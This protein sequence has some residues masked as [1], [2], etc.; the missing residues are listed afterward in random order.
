MTDRLTPLDATFL[1]L[2]QEDDCAHMHI[3]GALVFDPRADGSI[4][5]VEEL[6]AHLDARLGHLPRY[7][8]RLSA[9]RT[10]GLSWPVWEDD[11]HFDMAA[12]VRHA[13]LPAPG[14]E[15]ELCEWLGDYWSHRL[16]RTRPL[17]DVVLLEG[18]EGRALGARH[19]DAPRDGRRGGVDRRR[20]RSCSTPSPSSR[21]AL[22]ARA[23]GDGRRGAGSEP[24]R[25]LA[26]VG[27]AALG[28]GASRARCAARR[29]TWRSTRARWPRCS[30]AR[31]RQSR[32]S[33]AT[34][35]SARPRPRSTAG[36]ARRAGSRS[37]AFR[38]RT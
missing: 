27:G 37:C 26:P 5:T 8:R 2:E 13:A 12:H 9:P 38:L 3:G 33:C 19:E 36:S 18:L 32:C 20:A 34:S 31:A 28:A 17:W 21:G 1:E 16:D 30:S 29:R 23:A 25:E 10:G 35:W 24:L 6:R 14:G 4:P 11:E 22:S 7:R 15:A